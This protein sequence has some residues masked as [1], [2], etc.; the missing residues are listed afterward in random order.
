MEELMEPKVVAPVRV[1]VKHV[2][3]SIAGTAPVVCTSKDVLEAM[4][5]LL[6]DVAKMHVFPRARG[7]FYFEGLSVEHVEAEERFNEKEVDT[8]PDGLRVTCQPYTR[9][10]LRGRQLTPRQLLLPPNKCTV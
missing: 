10:L 3:I 8:K 1:E 2:V 4:L 7:A 9:Y 5:E 6:G